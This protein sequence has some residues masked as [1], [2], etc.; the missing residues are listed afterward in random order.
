MIAS[1][2]NK[3]K[4][5]DEYHAMQAVAT[6]IDSTLELSLLFRRHDAWAIESF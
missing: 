2:A 5:T 3:K 6:Y 1:Q 4:D